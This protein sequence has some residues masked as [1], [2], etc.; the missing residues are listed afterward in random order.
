MVVPA[1]ARA[2]GTGWLGVN[3]VDRVVGSTRRRVTGPVDVEAGMR[4][5]VP[6]RRVPRGAGPMWRRP[7]PPD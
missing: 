4:A 1:T 3:H 5:D 7:G 6:G 2:G